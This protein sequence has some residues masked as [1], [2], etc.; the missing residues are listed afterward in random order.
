MWQRWNGTSKIFEKSD[1]D[2]ASWTPLGLDA[3][4]ITQ[5]SLA[6]ARLSANIP[7][8]N[9]ANIFSGANTFSIAGNSFSEILGVSKGLAFPAVQVASANANTL[10]DYEEGV[11]T[12][13][14]V[15][16]GGGAATY[17]SQQGYYTKVGKLVTVTGYINT[18]TKGTLAAGNVTIT[19]LPFTIENVA[20]H[21]IGVNMPYWAGMTTAIVH[22]GG[23]GAPNTTV[24]TLVY[25]ASAG[26]SITVTTV[27]DL[28]ATTELMFTLS[29]RA[30]A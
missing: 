28:G 26:A 4:I 22:L 20:N 19:G 12:P 29:Y 24:F 30:A 21:F 1:N 25:R 11:W 6:D 13:V 17:S 2:G 15:S 18:A 16:S 8:K 23:F 27:A 3:A 10:D 5:G 14:I 7:L 9:A